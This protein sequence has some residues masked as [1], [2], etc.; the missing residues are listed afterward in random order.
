MRSIIQRQH[1]RGVLR[2]SF[3]ENMQ[4]IYRTLMPKC[5][6]NK[7]ALQLY[8]YRTSARVF[9]CKFAIY[10]RKR[11]PNISGR[12]P[13]IILSSR[14]LSS[15][16]VAYQW[17]HLSPVF[18]FTYPWKRQK[19][20]RFSGIFTVCK[21]GSLARNSLIGFNIMK[22]LAL[23]SLNWDSHRSYSVKKDALRNFEKFTGKHQC[24]SFFLIKPE[25]KT[26][27]FINKLTVNDNYSRHNKE[28]LSLPIEM[29]LS[30][31]L[32]TFCCFFIAFWEPTLNF[33]H[34]DK[35]S[36]SHRSIISE[37]I[38]FERRG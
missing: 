7:V 24:W 21:M 27:N 15:T 10:F 25:L 4:Q 28:K 19:T 1:S 38:D 36:E 8:W 17:T 3:S 2:K 26:S 5:D 11:F 18:P 23:N 31:K 12:L 14:I 29:R 34:F 6:F 30:K 33:E 37:I 20:R 13:L 9:P 22:T 35:K 32:K 16:C